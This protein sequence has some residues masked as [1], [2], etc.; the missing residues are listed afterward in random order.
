MVVKVVNQARQVLHLVALG[1]H[2]AEVE[3]LLALDLEIPAPVDDSRA[4][5]TEPL[6]RHRALRREPEI[7]AEVLVLH[8]PERVHRGLELEP[9]FRVPVQFR[10]LGLHGL[11][12]G[13]PHVGAEAAPFD[14][15]ETL[16]MR[17]GP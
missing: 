6:H 16:L 8:G 1:S 3:N 2:A 14:D 9:V 7:S 10:Y 17:R 15:D 12:G 11:A 4:C 13:P 5:F